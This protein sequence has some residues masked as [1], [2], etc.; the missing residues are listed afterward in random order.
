VV[1]AE[2]TAGFPPIADIIAGRTDAFKARGKTAQII[3][4]QSFNKMPK[5]VNIKFTN[6]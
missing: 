4:T 2:K 6:F 5:F 3:P 1:I